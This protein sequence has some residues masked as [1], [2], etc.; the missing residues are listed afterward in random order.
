MHRKN[1]IAILLFVSGIDINAADKFDIQV[2]EA[3]PRDASKIECYNN[4]RLNTSCNNLESS[5]QLSCYREST[6]TLL[7]NEE[8]Y[9]SHQ[10]TLATATD[11]ALNTGLPLL[12]APFHRPFQYI[13]M[14]VADAAKSTGGTPNKVNNIIIDS[15]Q[16][17][18]LLEAEG[19]FISFVDVELTKTAPC[20]QTVSFDPEPI[21]GALSI[22]PSELE[23]VRKKTHV[24]V[25]YD[26]KRKLKVSVSC[27]YDGAP[28]SVSFSSKYYGM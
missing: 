14:S 1:I 2:C 9:S 24:H 18:M 4:L 26:H 7:N 23:F 16:S 25:Y 19:N 6:E 11:K 10:E 3:Q 28:L 5:K 13:G 8:V 22:N 17:H 15:E 21:L 12:I 27:E 20:S